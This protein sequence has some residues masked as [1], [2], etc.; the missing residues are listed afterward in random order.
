MSFIQCFAPQSIRMRHFEK[1]H[2][3]FETHLL[4]KARTGFWQSK[5]IKKPKK[6]S[7]LVSFQVLV[8]DVHLSSES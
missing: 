6:V 5:L 7:A 8:E 3:I 4:L 2:G 1:V